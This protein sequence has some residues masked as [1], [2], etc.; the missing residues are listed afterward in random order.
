MYQGTDEQLKM[1]G[2]PEQLISRYAQNEWH[3]AG[4]QAH[5]LSAHYGGT[6]VFIGMH[7][8]VTGDHS[9]L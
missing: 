7:T 5:V 1:T 8:L 2:C 9:Y 4:R 3:T 6:T